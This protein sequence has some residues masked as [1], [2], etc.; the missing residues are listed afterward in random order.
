MLLKILII[1]IILVGLAFAGFAIK[2][3]SSKT[4]EFKKSCSSID[5]ATGQNY[6]CSCGNADGGEVCENKKQ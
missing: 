3:I 6:G 2:I 5:P 1:S 4:G